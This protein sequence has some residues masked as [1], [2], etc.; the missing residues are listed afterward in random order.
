M[1]SGCI[2]KDFSVM[3]WVGRVSTRTILIVLLR[4]EA[5]HSNGI[6]LAK[7]LTVHGCGHCEGYMTRLTS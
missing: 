5:L 7:G 2:K 6:E 4:R 3:D 1:Q